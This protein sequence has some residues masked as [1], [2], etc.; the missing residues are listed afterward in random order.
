MNFRGLTPFIFVLFA[1][2]GVSQ[3]Q[4]RVAVFTVPEV[5]VYAEAETSAEAQRIAQDRGRRQAMDILLRRLTA[6]EDWSYLP[7]L[8]GGMAAVAE[9]SELSELDQAI[10]SGKRVLTLSSADLPQLEEGFAIFD[11]KT[12]GK[13]YRARISYKFKPDAIRSLL[14]S[15]NLPY[16]ESQSRRSLVLP[17]LKT[18]ND[19]YLWETNNPWA[20][21]WLSRPLINE[22]TPLILPVGDRQDVEAA[23][24]E[25]VVDLNTAALAPFVSRYSAPQVIVAV[26]QLSEK[27]GEYQLYVRLIDGFL[28]ERTNDQKAAQDAAAQLYDSDDGFGTEAAPTTS[29]GTKGR[30]LA[31]AFFSGPSDDFPALAQ[32]A[33]ETVVTRYAKTWKQQTLVDHSTMRQLS[34]TAWFGSLDEWAQIRN[35]LSGTS[36]VRG[37]KVG[38]FNNENAVMELT[39]I[40]DPDQL[41]LEM[42]QQ[43]LTVWRSD[44]GN[45]NI[46]DRSRASQ[47]Q[48]ERVPVS[49]RGASDDRDGFSPVNRNERRFGEPLG[50]R[51]GPAPELPD[52]FLDDENDQDADDTVDLGE[53]APIYLEPDVEDDEGAAETD[54]DNDDE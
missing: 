20:R 7:D 25:D 30:V 22:L 15:A 4:T 18:E 44:D 28:A 49:F 33:V 26:G 34:L 11:E 45:W 27:N 42:R 13:T 5:P 3:A 48:S 29:V 37:M 23:T 2:L 36:L 24:A 32:R 9:A 47:L 50:M 38:A 35:A 41:I 12:S 8:S 54:D 6:E 19:V 53:G 40:G 39:V 52:D 14:Q 43:D 51:G 10:G 31:E 17:V 46:A 21:A 1:F 16:S